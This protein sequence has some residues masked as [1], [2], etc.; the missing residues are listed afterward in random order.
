[1]KTVSRKGLSG[2]IIK[3]L[4]SAILIIL[5]AAAFSYFSNPA[6]FELRIQDIQDDTSDLFNSISEE[7][8]KPPSLCGKNKQLLINNLNKHGE[9]NVGKISSNAILEYDGQGLAN[10]KAAGLGNTMYD[11]SKGNKEGQKT[12]ALYCEPSFGEG[13]TLEK[14]I[15]NQEGI[16]EKK[17]NF[18][19]TEIIMEE[20]EITDLRCSK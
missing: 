14:T 12:D 17:E 7:K 2:S 18:T 5:F 11:C 16:I 9:M 4:K 6:M 8:E 20:S 1:M 15:T 13:M 3:F 10:W 19:L